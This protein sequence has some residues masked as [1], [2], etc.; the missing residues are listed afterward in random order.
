MKC[1]PTMKTMKLK[2]FG[3]N[4]KCDKTKETAQ[5]ERLRVYMYTQDPD[6]ER[7]KKSKDRKEKGSERHR[8]G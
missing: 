2:Q 8:P 4:G 5:R 6:N 3:L 1:N 7:K